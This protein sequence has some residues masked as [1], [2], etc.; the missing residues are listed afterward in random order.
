MHYRQNLHNKRHV[1]RNECGD[2]ILD[3]YER[4][5]NYVGVLADITPMEKQYIA[6]LAKAKGSWL[7]VSV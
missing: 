5:W 6:S 2:E 7:Q 4:G 1:Y 3:R